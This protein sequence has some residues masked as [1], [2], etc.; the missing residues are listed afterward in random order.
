MFR[1][2]NELYHSLVFTVYVFLFCHGR[3]RPSLFHFPPQACLI[4]KSVDLLVFRLPDNLFGTFSLII[5]LLS[6]Q[7]L[8]YFF[9]LQSSHSSLVMSLCALMRPWSAYFIHSGILSCFFARR[10]LNLICCIPITMILALTST[11]DRTSP[12]PVSRPA[13]CNL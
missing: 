4:L 2:C 5:T 7:C 3:D 1:A 10:G 8:F 6:N 11:R 12:V 13:H 9:L